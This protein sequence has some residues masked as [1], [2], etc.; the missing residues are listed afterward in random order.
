M[1]E[2]TSQDH[3]HDRAMTWAALLGKWAEFAKSAV[4]LPDEGPEGRLK[5]VVADVIALQSL[6]HALGEIDS[7]DAD[8][9]SLGL[10]R[11][12]IGIRKHASAINAAFAGEIMPEG[13]ADLVSDA[14]LALDA[15]SSS[16]IEWCVAGGP[17]ICPH[18]SELVEALV[19]AGFSGDLFVPTPG[20][21]VFAPAP[22]AFV[23]HPGGAPIEPEL[24]DVIGGFLAMSGDITD[25]EQRS[26]PRQ[27]YRQFDFSK[28][29][30][31]RDYVV[32][33]ASDLPPGQPLLVPAIMAGEAQ[34]VTL[35]VPGADRQG[36]L[37]VEFA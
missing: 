8:E 30:P 12:E 1:S 21:P 5:A 24:A 13:L 23:R 18:P 26:E 11:A 6:T 28:G 33:L 29:G 7:L 37:P 3:R 25:A 16:G 9:R 32:P 17:L 14:Q 22:C 4:A 36:E 35:P 2:P 10:D 34:P 15:A 31:V 19:G 27:V 20:V